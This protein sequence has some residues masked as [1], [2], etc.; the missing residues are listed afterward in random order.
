VRDLEEYCRARLPRRGR[1]IRLSTVYEPAPVV[2]ANR[3]LLEWAL[4]NL[5]KNAVDALQAT[6][7]EISLRVA[8]GPVPGTAMVEISDN[9]PG[10]PWAL[11]K[12]IFETGVSTKP[13]GW[14]VGLSLARRIVEENHGGSLE[15][16]ASEP[17]TGTTFRVTLAA[18]DQDEGARP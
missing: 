17:G 16:V 15:L 8:R 12:R 3:T 10:V 14:G 9:G 2:E 5:V 7:G 13:Q 18:S 6:G 1:T 4:E 11:R